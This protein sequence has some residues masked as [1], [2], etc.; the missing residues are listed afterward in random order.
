ML[1]VRF[2]RLMGTVG[3]NVYYTKSDT[4][5]IIDSSGFS[6][7]FACGFVGPKSCLLP[8]MGI[9][10]YANAGENSGAPNS[11]S[12]IYEWKG[13]FSWVHG[14]HTFNMGADFNTDNLGPDV[15]AQPSE[16]FGAIET[17][18]IE[19][20]ADPGVPWR[21]FFWGFPTTRPG[22]T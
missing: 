7:D 18:N 16:G 5:Q 12:D 6:K 21:H 13:D 17:A 9:T 3:P 1:Q 22:V 20:P 2:N 11:A 8:G 15:A 4:T 10:G 14:R 19:N